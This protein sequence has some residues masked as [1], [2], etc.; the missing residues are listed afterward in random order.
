[1]RVLVMFLLPTGACM[2]AGWPNH[3]VLAIAAFAAGM[4][5]IGPPLRE[6]P[7][8][9]GGFLPPPTR[10]PSNLTRRVFDYSSSDDNRGR[11]A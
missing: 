5:A 2:G 9:R 10:E 1:M 3:W 8:R 11:G 7:P 6:R 4:I